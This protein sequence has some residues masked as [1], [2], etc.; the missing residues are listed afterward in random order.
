MA[1][2]GKYYTEKDTPVFREAK[3]MRY[4]RKRCDRIAKRNQRS[5]R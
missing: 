5:Y 2:K 4:I 1:D 3:A